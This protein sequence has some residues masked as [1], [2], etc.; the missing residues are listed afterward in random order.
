MDAAMGALS[1]VI[2]LLVQDRRDGVAVLPGIPERWSELD[3]DGIAC[4][5]GFL[6]GVTVR[7]RAIAEVRVLSRRGGELAIRIGHGPR[8]VMPTTPGQRLVLH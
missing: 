8:Q 6:I 7:R 1:A 5:G 3:A 2:D 4:E